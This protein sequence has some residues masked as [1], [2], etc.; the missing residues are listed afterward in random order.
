M[1]GTEPPFKVRACLMSLLLRQL[2]VQGERFAASHPYPWLVWEPGSWMPPKVSQATVMVAAS[3]RPSDRPS[4]GDALCYELVG[5]DDRGRARALCI[6]RAQE[7]DIVLN[8]ATVSRMHVTLEVHEDGRWSLTPTSSSKATSLQGLALQPGERAWLSPGGRLSL[9][10]VALTFYDAE[11]FQA[12]LGQ[13]RDRQA[14]QGRAEDSDF[15]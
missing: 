8:D 3:A 13:E 5:A 14:R 15:D 9:G 4:A 6:G 2:V 11:G 12:R 7:N 10:D 1:L